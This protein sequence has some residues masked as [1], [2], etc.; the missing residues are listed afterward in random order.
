MQN[1]LHTQIELHKKCD[2]MWC[3]GALASIVVIS[4]CHCQVATVYKRR[5]FSVWN[6]T[7]NDTVSNE[8]HSHMAGKLSCDGCSNLG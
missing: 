4:D 5:T 6:S 8:E 3:G 7:E 1:F 2:M